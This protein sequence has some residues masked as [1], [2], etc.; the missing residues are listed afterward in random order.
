LL[1]R[2]PNNRPCNGGHNAPGSYFNLTMH[3]SLQKQPVLCQRNVSHSFSG[4]QL[5]HLWPR[6]YWRREPDLGIFTKIFR[7]T[8]YKRMTPFSVEIRTPEGQL[9]LTVSAACR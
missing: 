1:Q 2:A 8:D 3:A 7:F 5:R 9:V 4:Q 6:K